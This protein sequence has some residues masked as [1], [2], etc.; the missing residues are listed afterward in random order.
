LEAAVSE[1]TRA[2]W[3]RRGGWRRPGGPRRR[4]AL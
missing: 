3:D 1:L 2:R 4:A